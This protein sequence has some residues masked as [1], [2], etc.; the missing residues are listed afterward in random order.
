MSIKVEH[1][2]NWEN[3]QEYVQASASLRDEE[4]TDVQVQKGLRDDMIAALSRAAGDA[5]WSE[6]KRPIEFD[7]D[8]WRDTLTNQVKRIDVRGTMSR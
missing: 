6:V 1:H 8:V 3:G 2:L 7:Q 5:G 4:V